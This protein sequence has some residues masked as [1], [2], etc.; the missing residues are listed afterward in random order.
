MEFLLKS[1]LIIITLFNSYF[2]FAQS[3]ISLDELRFSIP[4]Y[5]WLNKDIYLLKGQYLKIPLGFEEITQNKDGS[6]T[7]KFTVY[8]DLNLTNPILGLSRGE[9]L[10]SHGST[11]CQL[12]PSVEDVF[13]RTYVHC[14]DGGCEMR[15]VSPG[16]PDENVATSLELSYQIRKSAKE[17]CPFNLDYTYARLSNEKQSTTSAL[18]RFNKIIENRILEIPVNGKAAYINIS[19]CNLGN[20]KN[21]CLI[22]NFEK[23]KIELSH[24]VLT[25]MQK[26]KSH[27]AL[28]KAIEQLL[29]CVKKR[30]LDCVKRYITNK[31]DEGPDFIETVINDEILKELLACLD[32]RRLLPHLEAS[33]GINKFC[34]FNTDESAKPIRGITK[35]EALSKTGI[36][37]L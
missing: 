28:N 9:I 10:N 22:E 6:E 15:N 3:S 19:R 5:D 36:N 34:I 20:K 25:E 7:R 37:T 18:I 26:S 4:A 16:A 23:T 11:I 21:F 31:N 32:Y 17:V 33:Q 14:K 12:L 13:S 27:T 35:I 30:D 29:P 24:E 1:L 8:S 2:L